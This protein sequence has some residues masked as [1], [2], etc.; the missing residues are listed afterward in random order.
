VVAEAGSTARV[1]ACDDE[2]TVLPETIAPRTLF[3][4]EAV[5]YAFAG[6]QARLFTLYNA[7]RKRRPD[8]DDLAR[9]TESGAAA[10]RLAHADRLGTRWN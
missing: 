2:A 1:V 9:T 8:A 5:R 3:A 7:C 4:I 10:R 6:A